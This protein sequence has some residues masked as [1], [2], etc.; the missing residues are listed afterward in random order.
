MNSFLFKRVSLALLLFVALQSFSQKVYKYESVPNDPLN[1]RIYTLDNGL[2]VYMS[3]YKDAPRIQT[4]IAV[5]TGSKNDPNDNTGLSH[6]LEHL[7]FKGTTHFSTKDF[8]KENV[9]LTKIDSLFE[10]YRKLTDPEQRK[11]TYKIIDSISNIAAS[12]AIANEYDKMMASLGVKGTNAYTSVDQTV[13]VNDVPSNQFNKWLDIEFDRFSNPV[14]RIF[15]TEL[16]TIYEEKNMSLDNDGRKIYEALLDGLFPTHNYGQHTTLGKPEHLKNPSLV[17]LK[18]YFGNRYVPNNMAIVLSG[19]FNPDLIIKKIDENF[20][21]MKSKKLNDYVP[22]VEK[23]ITQPIVKEVKGPD[24]ESMMLAFRFGGAKSTDLDKLSIMDYI[25]AN[26]TAGLIDL[27]LVQAQK[28]LSAGSSLY[29]MTDYTAHIFSGKPKQGQK[30][31]EVKDLLLE[32]IEKV[33]KGDFADWLIPAIINDLKLLEIHESESRNSRNSSMIDAFVSGIS[34][35]DKVNR[36]KRLSQ[37]T[38]KDIIDF[39]NKNYN[40]NYVVVYKRTG[41]NPDVVKIEKPS[42]TPVK[43]DRD[44][45]SDFFK[46]ITS[47]KVDPIEP[48]FLDYAKDIVTFKIKDD[49]QVN[50]L[51]NT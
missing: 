28:V 39:A 12:Y 9:Y 34:W 14:F 4:A 41:A 21:Q 24:A 37:I 49:I 46:K 3:V 7:M 40:N 2:K 16:E 44:S 51:K 36:M 45:Q 26:S 1:V 17:S 13:Y 10:V 47:Q 38:K 23:P 27:N 15:H 19:D 42:I 33:K 43:I 22:P 18:E 29:E 6:Y 20:G 8:G 32:Q 30:L 48:V 11:N 50:Y 25:L 31:E 5:R 35:S